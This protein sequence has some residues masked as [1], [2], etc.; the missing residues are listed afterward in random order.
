VGGNVLCYLPL[1]R[2]GALAG[3]VYGIQSPSAGI[4]AAPWTV[5]SLAELYLG[6]LQEVQ[7]QGPYL[8]AGWSMGGVVAFE[9]ARLLRATGNEVALVA[10]VDVASPAESVALDTGPAEGELVDFLADLAALAAPGLAASVELAQALGASTS[11]AALLEHEDIRAALPADLGAE[12][13]EEMFAL[14]RAHRRALVTYRPGG[15]DGSS[16]TLIR[17][18]E[19]AAESP[20]ASR[21]WSTLASDGAEVHVLPGDHYSLFRPAGVGTLAALLESCVRRALAGSPPPA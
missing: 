2:H 10:M 11:L 7:P 19:T 20:D 8:L 6:A 4:L 3:P 1:A 16:L 13:L 18:A 17:A 14:F 21:E 5:E 9:M 15:Y 12:R